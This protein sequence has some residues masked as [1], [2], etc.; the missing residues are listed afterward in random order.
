MSLILDCPVEKLPERGRDQAKVIDV[1]KR[2]H[3]INATEATQSRCVYIRWED[4]IEKQYRRYC[5]S[6]GLLIFYRHQ[7]SGHV[8]SLALN[9]CMPECLNFICDDKYQK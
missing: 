2:A 4:G 1:K 3:K 7:I 9:E 8:V 5:K 6:C